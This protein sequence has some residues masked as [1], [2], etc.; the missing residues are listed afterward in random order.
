MDI[1]DITSA[2][3]T[4]SDKSCRASSSNHPPQAFINLKTS[5]FSRRVSFLFIPSKDNFESV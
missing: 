4:L 3:R 1:P 2:I 5:T